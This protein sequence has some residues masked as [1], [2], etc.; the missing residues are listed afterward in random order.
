MTSVGQPTREGALQPLVSVIIPVHNAGNYLQQCL[1]SVRGQTLQDI[2]IIA[3]DDASTDSSPELLAQ[4]EARDD[5]VR[6]ITL[7][8]NRGVSAARNAGLA[9]ARG[10]FVAF[11]DADDYIDPAM[12]QTMLTA[13]QSLGCD[14]VSCGIETVESVGSRLDVTPF[15][16]PPGARNDAAEMRERLHDA[17]AV[18]MLW[19]PFRSLYK[20]ELL[21]R[22]GLVFDEGVRKGE[23]SLFNLQVLHFADG[24]CC[25]PDPMYHYRQ[26][27]ASATAKPLASES[28]NLANLANG[29]LGF[30]AEHGYDQRASADF[31]RHVLS[32]DLPTAL[33]R[34]ATHPQMHLQITELTN[35]DVVRA[36]FGAQSL[37][38]M[39]LPASVLVLLVMARARRPGLIALAVRVRTLVL[40]A[41]SG[42]YGQPRP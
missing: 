32:S 8:R 7:A 38:Q 21:V 4:I 30:Y 42:K 24:V 1:D 26:H 6:V 17:F 27:G 11:V 34:L 40:G 16:L 23:D 28:Q 39:D 29:V 36:A 25:I 3:V 10:E 13:A 2:E 41:L 33:V 14:V 37:R 15:P 18:R 12:Y 31:Y 20:R 9:A 5:R 35:L 19:F 22:Q